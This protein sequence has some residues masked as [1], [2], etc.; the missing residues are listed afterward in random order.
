MTLQATLFQWVAAVVR[1]FVTHP[2]GLFGKMRHRGGRGD[3]MMRATPCK[4]L[5]LNPIPLPAMVQ[6]MPRRGMAMRGAKGLR[7]GA[8]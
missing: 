1:C 5:N 4:R 6:G 8:S 3:P 2:E 7:I